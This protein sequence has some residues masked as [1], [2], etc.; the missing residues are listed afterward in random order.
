MGVRYYNI[1]WDDT[2]VS[3]NI[4]CLNDDREGYIKIN[5]TNDKYEV[6]GFK[7]GDIVIRGA[8]GIAL[9]VIKKRIRKQGTKKAVLLE[10]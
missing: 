4:K 2:Y 9:D 5:I 6:I 7:S 3:M 8:F 10:G 1:R